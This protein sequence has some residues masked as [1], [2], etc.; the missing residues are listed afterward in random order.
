M[1]ADKNP[2]VRT[3]LELLP[4][5]Q[6]NKQFIL[7]RDHLGLVEE[8]KAVPLQLYELITL[9]DGTNTVRDLQMVLMRQRGGVL[10][11]IDEVEALLAH[12]DES[13]LLDT[14]RYQ[15]AKN[16]IVAQFT[17]RSARPCSHCG[18]SYPA[19]P[20]DLVNKLDDILRI[21]SP[22]PKPAGKP[23]A[24]V[25]PHIDLSVGSRVYASAYQWLKHASPSRV[26]V[27][28]VGHQIRDALFCL[29]KKDFETPLGVIETDR[30]SVEKLW[31]A[32]REVISPNDFAHKAEHSVEFQVIFLQHLFQEKSFRIIPILCGP[33]MTCL[34]AYNR[35]AYRQTAKTF[36]TM[37]AEIL[38][39]GTQETLVIAGVDF[40]H[41]GLKFGHDKPATYLQGQTERHDQELLKALSERKTDAFW[42][43]S[44]RARDQFNVCGFSA[45]ACLSEVLPLAKGQ[46]LGYEIWHE[47]PTR[48]AVSFAAVGFTA[49]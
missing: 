28:G 16:N 19:Q 12:L 18:R 21:Q 6:G 14:E 48:S 31:G 39:D 44:I 30:D 43:E 29:T 25:A 7:I 41:I 35:A 34:S 47:Q 13:F 37:L 1:K 38:R 2:R 27:L 11:G 32:G 42:E 20:T 24:L 15:R 45:M 46:V 33:L 4:I 22:F 5:Q 49:T 10:V 36:L 26:V 9:L 40:S 3:D 8:G 17:E 23:V